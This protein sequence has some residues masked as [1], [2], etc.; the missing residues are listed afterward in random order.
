MII[1][2]QSVAYCG[3]LVVSWT[4]AAVPEARLFHVGDEFTVGSASSLIGFAHAPTD[5]YAMLDS[6]LSVVVTIPEDMLSGC[7]GSLAVGVGTAVSG[8]NF[9][10]TQSVRRGRAATYYCSKRVALLRVSF[11]VWYKLVVVF[12]SYSFVKVDS[13]GSDI[14][15]N[16]YTYHVLSVVGGLGVRLS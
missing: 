5:A 3:Q 16:V 6:E 8:D 2:G 1:V 13:R 4:K 9:S 10:G 11:I 12:R 15:I 7:S 14:D